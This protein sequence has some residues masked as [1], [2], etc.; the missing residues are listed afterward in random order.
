MRSQRLSEPM[1]GLAHSEHVRVK[2]LE[3]Q[4]RRV[5]IS[6]AL[7][8]AT[9][10]ATEVANVHNDP[11]SQDMLALGAREVSSLLRASTRAG[12]GRAKLV[13]KSQQGCS[14]SNESSE[15]MPT[16]KATLQQTLSH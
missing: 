11:D 9:R 7:S 2:F 13:A 14:Q 1:A 8:A 10:H 4:A 5:H 12:S 15:S 16:S 3:I 6:A